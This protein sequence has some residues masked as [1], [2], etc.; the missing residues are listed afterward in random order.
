[1]TDQEWL[2]GLKKE[3][4]RSDGDYWNFNIGSPKLWRKRRKLFNTT[5]HDMETREPFSIDST[6]RDNRETATG[7]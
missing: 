6:C 5:K 4:S 7:K 2:E 1:M 3:L